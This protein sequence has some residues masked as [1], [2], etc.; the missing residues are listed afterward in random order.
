MEVVDPSLSCR[1]AELSKGG[2]G[3]EQAQHLELPQ[4]ADAAVTRL[5]RRLSQGLLT[6]LR[7]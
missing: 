3:G 1:N 7:C 5:P 4:D 2:C 6:E